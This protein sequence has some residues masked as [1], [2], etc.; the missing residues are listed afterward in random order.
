MDESV[1]AYCS[2]VDVLLAKRM[3]KDL[4]MSITS[5]R[6]QETSIGMSSGSKSVTVPLIISEVSSLVW[7]LT[8][9][10]VNGFGLLRR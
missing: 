5:S 9:F 3:F 8:L 6:E 1:S 7:A 10:G 2:I 4:S